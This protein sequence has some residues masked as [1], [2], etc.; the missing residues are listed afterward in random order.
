MD[1]KQMEQMAR[2]HDM[3]GIDPQFA[4]E[5]AGAVAK[6]SV[7]AY[8]K[9]ENGVVTGYKKIET[10]VVSGYKKIE[11]GV[12]NGYLKIQDGIVDGFG[13]LISKC[14]EVMFARE[15]ETVE[16]AKARLSRKAPEVS[17]EAQAA[18]EA[19]TQK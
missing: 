2:E 4:E 14:V 18:E 1:N 15:G 17:E 10:G 6:G 5:V 19:Q 7:S 11:N 9:I 3:A 16:Q 12:V 8:Q 13:K